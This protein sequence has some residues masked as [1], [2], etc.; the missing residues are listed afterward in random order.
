MT[1][2]STIVRQSE[3]LN[4][5]ILDRATMEELGQVETLW[6]YP[7]KH[8]I[9][10]LISKSGFLGSKKSAFNLAQLDTLGDGS[11]LV[12]SPPEPT[13]A[14]K[15]QQL[16]SLI[17]CE[18]WTDVGKKVGEITDCLFNLRTG[19]ISNY[20]FV[21]SRWRGLTDGVYML[22]PDQIRSIGKMR[23]L[24]ADGA[25]SSL[26]IYSPGIKQQLTRASDAIKADYVHLT[27]D[28]RSVAE[29]AKTTA[30]QTGDLLQSLTGQVKE[31]AKSL[32]QQA[33]EKAQRLGEQVKDSTQTLAYQA[34]ETGQS[35]I[36]NLQM[37][38]LESDW[39]PYAE[40][41]VES[42]LQTDQ[43]SDATADEVWS[44]WEEPSSPP[45]Q[46]TQ[47]TQ[48]VQPPKPTYLVTPPPASPAAS[49]PDASP[50][51]P[52]HQATSPTAAPPASQE[53]PPAPEPRSSEQPPNPPSFTEWDASELSS[54]LESPEILTTI[55]PE[56]LADDDPWI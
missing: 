37:P 51:A 35:L 8:R 31:Q 4:L 53:T 42:D 15:V 41:D 38:D 47:P 10:G 16:Q 20:L 3:L 29:K 45:V 33:K 12:N 50:A 46:A 48:P 26:K 49:I 30:G 36:N 19:A 39:D 7:Q 27:D 14:K 21:V 32:V 5:L 22:P 23:V 2:R 56:D 28:V 52:T 34:K 40:P 13:D 54:V 6:M 25:M 24:V 9:L 55:P 44:D 1:T 17:H 43:E 11:I 18:V